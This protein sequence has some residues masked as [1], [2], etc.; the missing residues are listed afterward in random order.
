LSSCSA[1][2]RSKE[3]LEPFPTLA[4]PWSP[5]D[6]QFKIDSLSAQLQIKRDERKAKVEKREKDIKELKE[7]VEAKR[8]VRGERMRS[9]GGMLLE[10]ARKEPE[11]RLCLS[12]F[13]LVHPLSMAITL[14]LLGSTVSLTTVAPSSYNEAHL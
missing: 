14:P 7:G 1:Y 3:R 9:K 2:R 13:F 11:V 4:P 10:W 8:A 12:S 6:F 5:T